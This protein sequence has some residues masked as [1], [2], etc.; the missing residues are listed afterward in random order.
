MTPPDQPPAIDPNR[1]RLVPEPDHQPEPHF[2]PYV[3]LSQ[4]PSDE[5]LAV[6]D[7][8]LRTFIF[9]T[10]AQ[11]FSI[12]L[13]FPRFEGAAYDRAVTLAR[14]ARGYRESGSGDQIRSFARF[15][16]EDAAALRTLYELVGSVDGAEVLVDE[17]AWPFARELWLPLFW[18]LLPR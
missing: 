2:W 15:Q 1:P 13:S 7:P 18:Y 5:E 3:D 17:R 8:D 12:T 6:M 14:Q 9:G 11:P 16:P 4:H 10:L